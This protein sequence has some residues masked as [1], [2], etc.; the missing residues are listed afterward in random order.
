MTLS[1]SYVANPMMIA[2]EDFKEKLVIIV[3]ASLYVINFNF[4]EYSMSMCLKDVLLVNKD[5]LTQ[6]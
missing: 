5:S 1:L 3:I 6:S 2:Q 4:Q